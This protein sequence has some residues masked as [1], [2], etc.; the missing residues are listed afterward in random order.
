MKT[1]RMLRYLRPALSRIKRML[2]AIALL[3]LCGSFIALLPPYLSKL[4]FDRSATKFCEVEVSE[5]PQPAGN[6]M[7]PPTFCP[8]SSSDPLNSHEQKR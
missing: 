5:G 2:G 8:P 1:W 6:G 3:T 4:L 7:Y